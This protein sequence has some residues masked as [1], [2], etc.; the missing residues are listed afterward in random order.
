MLPAIIAW[1][2]GVTVN[3]KITPFVLKGWTVKINQA[4]IGES[5][6][7]ILIPLKGNGTTNTR[8]IHMTHQ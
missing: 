1:N 5:F 2:C 8:V 7:V 3:Y 4:A 6:N